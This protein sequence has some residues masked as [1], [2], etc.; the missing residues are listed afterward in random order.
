MNKDKNQDV[1]SQADLDNLLRMN[2]FIE[3]Q[4]ENSLVE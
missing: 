1:L 3:P 4:T 2:E